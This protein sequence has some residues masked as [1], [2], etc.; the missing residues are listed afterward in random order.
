MDNTLSY[1]IDRLHKHPL[2]LK[3]RERTNKTI[4]E[5]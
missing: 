2:Y 1:A 5:R 4:T 3:S